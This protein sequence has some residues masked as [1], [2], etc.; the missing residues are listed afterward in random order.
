MYAESEIQ[1]FSVSIQNFDLQHV[2]G[3]RTYVYLQYIYT[4]C[5]YVVVARK[6]SGS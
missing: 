2:L 3:G 5:K 4:V 6:F 1:T